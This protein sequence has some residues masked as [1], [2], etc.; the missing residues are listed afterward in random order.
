MY[1]FQCSRILALIFLDAEKAFDNVSWAFIKTQLEYV[2][3]GHWTLQTIEQIYCSQFTKIVVNNDL[4][5]SVLNK[6]G[7]RQGC[8]LSPLLFILS[9]EGLLL[10]IHPDAD[11]QGLKM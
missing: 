6:K 3:F 4:T 10:Q 7:T 5:D 1:Y 2:E 8:H 9:L 11:I